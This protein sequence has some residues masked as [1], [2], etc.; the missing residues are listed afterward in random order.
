MATRLELEGK[1]YK[2][3]EVLNAGYIAL[4][5]YMGSDLSICR[6]ARV[7]YD[8]AWRA[9]E[10][11]GSD[12]RLINYLM[13]NGHN[14]PFE[15]GVVTIEVKLP[16]FVTRQ[17]HRHRT[18]CLSGDTRIK[19]AKPCDGKP[20]WKTLQELYDQWHYPEKPV[21]RPDKQTRS[22]TEFNRD[23][24]RNMEL[25][26][27]ED[28]KEV[29]TTFITDVI[30]SG[31]KEVFRITGHEGSTIKA[32][33]DHKFQTTEGWKRL[34]ELSVGD[35]ILTI[36]KIAPESTK[37]SPPFTDQELNAE[38]W[39]KCP[40]YQLTYVS[41]LGRVC[42]NNKIRQP[43]LNAQG[44]PVVS[45]KHRDGHWCTIQIS[46]LVATHMLKGEGHILH[47]DDCPLNNRISNL[48]YGTDQDNHDQALANGRRAFNG[49]TT[50]KIISIESVG[51]EM[52]Y[53]IEVEHPDHNFIAENFCTHN[54]YNEVS[55]RYKEL[56]EEFF[57]PDVCSI[58]YQSDDNKQMRTNQQH[59]KAEEMQLLMQLTN[60]Q[61]FAAYQALISGGCPRELARSV[62]P[63]GTYTH[64]FATFNLHN[65]LRFLHERL[66][67]H[68]QYEIYVYAKAILEVLYELFPVT[69]KAF[70][71]GLT[72]NYSREDLQPLLNRIK[73]G[74]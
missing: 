36:G 74:N 52:T 46:R 23:R 11:A 65:G 56:P 51:K 5:D 20:Y 48:Q 54:S 72:E 39:V 63:V 55:A 49:V 24:I 45:L 10:D 67:N 21:K 31:D 14:T 40:N 3:I 62:L 47:L 57:V 68:A 28:G 69:I 6:N 64:M 41:S 32:S 25:Y 12:K 71:T 18:Q 50:I 7:S 43:T 61:S 13:R 42:R 59:P 26:C 66:H 15:S 8:A 35:K 73:T 58:T 2:R 38:Y 1:K 17:W 53:D 29:T 30:R 19:F 16:I 22:R 60:E 27:I 33:K 44:R 70:V 34:E 9:G 4:V 37:D